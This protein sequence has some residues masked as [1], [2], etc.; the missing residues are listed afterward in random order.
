MN[1]LAK[2]SDLFA[3]GTLLEVA[4]HDLFEKL[5]HGEAVTCPCCER[6]A[7]IYERKIHTT[8]AKQ[9]IEFYHLGGYSGYLHIKETVGNKRSGSGD[10]TKLKYWNLIEKSEQPPKP[11]QKSSGW[12]KITEPG[13]KF[14]QNKISVPKYAIVWDDV[15]LRF[16]DETTT[17]SEA[18]G[19]KFSYP[20]LMGK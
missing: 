7:K 5:K 8:M 2:Q 11:E 17:I 15:V 14:L 1:A 19:E 18:L 4:K 6:F 3:G 9:L 10:F 20:E 12:W 13:F 16:S